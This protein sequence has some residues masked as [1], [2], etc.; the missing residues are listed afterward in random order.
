M[1]S[2]IIVSRFC[3][4]ILNSVK[5]TLLTVREVSF[6]QGRRSAWY[7]SEGGKS[8]AASTLALIQNQWK[9]K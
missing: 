3:E 2:P 1:P 4:S 6:D 8:L 9:A 7:F 5:E